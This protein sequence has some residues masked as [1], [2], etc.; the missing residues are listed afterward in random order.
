MGYWTPPRDGADDPSWWRPL[1]TLA[2]LL[3]VVPDV[4]MVVPCDFRLVGRVERPGR[5]PIWQYRHKTT[6]RFLHIDDALVVYRERVTGRLGRDRGGWRSALARLELGVADRPDPRGHCGQCRA[7]LARRERARDGP[8]G[9][10]SEGRER[11]PGRATGPGRRA[12][13]STVG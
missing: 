9:G 8:R 7:L 11:C 13:T 1:A 6:G 5:A 12:V 2:E 3:A 10:R 4:P